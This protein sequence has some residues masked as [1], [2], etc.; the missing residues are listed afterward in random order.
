MAVVARAV[1]YRAESRRC[2]DEDFVRDGDTTS[3]AVSVSVVDVVAFSP[4]PKFGDDRWSAAEQG[5]A[6]PERQRSD[7]FW[8]HDWD[9]AY[10]SLEGAGAV[11][12]DDERVGVLVAFTD[13]RGEVLKVLVAEAQPRMTLTMAASQIAL[14]A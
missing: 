6:G 5:Q 8:R 14:A 1:R 12:A 10:G 4:A 13:E 2:G 3:V 9:A 11:V 7:C